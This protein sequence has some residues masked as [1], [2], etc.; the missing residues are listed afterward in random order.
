VISFT[1]QENEGI[2]KFLEGDDACIPISEYR[3]LHDRPLLRPNFLTEINDLVDRVGGKVQHKASKQKLATVLTEEAIKL[4]RYL[5][6]ELSDDKIKEILLIVR[7][8][9]TYC[10][11]I[12]RKLK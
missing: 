11:D 10:S 7:N 3:Y 1:I 5:D 9:Y 6:G 2:R 12:D 8:L 4:G